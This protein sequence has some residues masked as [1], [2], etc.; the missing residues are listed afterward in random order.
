MET[1]ENS[2]EILT[3]S[4]S[5]DEISI[6]S[7]NVI[8]LEGEGETENTTDYEILWEDLIIKDQIGEGI[9]QKGIFTHFT[10]TVV[11]MFYLTSLC[12]IWQV[13]MRLFFTQCG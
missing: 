8:T 3:C 11:L 9:Y 6:K 10:K 5:T 1:L 12:V 13:H 2:S 4:A 7:G